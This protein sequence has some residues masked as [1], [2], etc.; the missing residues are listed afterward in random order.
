MTPSCSLVSPVCLRQILLR[1]Q[2]INPSPQICLM[3]YKPVQFISQPVEVHF[4]QAP[5]LEKKPGAPDAFTWQET[6]FEVTEV[7]SEWVDYQRR[8]RMKR[9]MQPQHAEVASHRGSW[10]VG[11]FYFRVRTHQGRIFDLYYD[12]AP[13]DVDRRKGSWFLFQELI[14]R[15]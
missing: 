11:V 1:L 3:E 14:E 5:L 8:G 2:P 7:L 13:K 6:R 4:T 15:D 12:R 10:G 9:N